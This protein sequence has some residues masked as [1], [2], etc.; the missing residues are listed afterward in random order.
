[1]QDQI[2][3][4]TA[5]IDSATNAYGQQK[6]NNP[7]IKNAIDK[8]Y[9]NMHANLLNETDDHTQTQG[10]SNKEDRVQA[11]ARRMQKSY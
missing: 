8:G 10:P 5:G 7:A 1:M 3:Q 4:P 11:M 2:Y 9:A 6:M